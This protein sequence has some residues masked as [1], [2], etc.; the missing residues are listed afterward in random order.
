MVVYFFII[1]SLTRPDFFE[2]YA[3]NKNLHL[4]RILSQKTRYVVR[5]CEVEKAVD[6]IRVDYFLSFQP[7]K[8]G[9]I[10][11]YTSTTYHYL[12]TENVDI[13][14]QIKLDFYLF[15]R[16]RK[17]LN[18]WFLKKY[19]TNCMLTVEGERD[20]RISCSECLWSS[21]FFRFG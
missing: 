1:I 7:L 13:P 6:L 14:G 2:N 17:C 9:F 8:I 10:C 19:V 12:D 16:F 21:S 11:D 4:S 18:N 15:S 5:P 3:Y 20:L